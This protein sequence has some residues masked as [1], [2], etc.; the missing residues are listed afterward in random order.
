MTSAEAGSAYRVR[1]EDFDGPLDLL[2]HLVRR[3][4]LDAVEIPISRIADQFVEHIERASRVDVE[5]GGEFLVMAATL[6]EIKSRSLMPA[7]DAGAAVRAGKDEEDPGAS[8]IGQLLAYRTF[9]DAAERLDERRTRF[10]RYWP[11]AKIGVDRDSIRELV[12][13]QGDADLEDLTIGD[14]IAAFTTVA[15]AVNFERLGE[16]RVQ[17]EDTPIELHAA[18]VLER[19]GRQAT[20]TG[21]ARLTFAELFA[22]ASRPEVIGLFLA[23]LELTRQRKIAVEHD[24]ETGMIT[25][26]RREDAEASATASA[27]PGDE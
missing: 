6:M 9:R 17:F 20:R 21:T 26:E 25:I 19:L 14:L 11:A 7:E 12:E 27:E 15:E 2:L 3:S 23:T 24:A 8:L 1:L 10:E 16:H 4:E 18:D 13:A 22:G 5:V